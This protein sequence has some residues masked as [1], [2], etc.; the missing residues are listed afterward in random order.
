MTGARRLLAAALTAAVVF[1]AW[2]GLRAD[3]ARRAEETA[4]AARV[5]DLP[6]D[7]AIVELEIER[8]RDGVRVS[9]ARDGEGVWRLLEPIEARAAESAIEG[10]LT[11]L[12]QRESTQTISDATEAAVFGF[13]PPSAVVR[14]RGADGAA[15]TLE[16]GRDTPYGGRVYVRGGP[17]SPIHVVEG[18]FQHA[19]RRPLDDWRDRRLLAGFPEEITRVVFTTPDA[20]WAITAAA[21][22]WFGPAGEALAAAKVEPLLSRIRFMAVDGFRPDDEPLAVTPASIMVEAAGGRKATL[23]FG[24]PPEGQGAVAVD[25]PDLRGTVSRYIYDSLW[26]RPEDLAPEPATAPESAVTPA[27]VDQAE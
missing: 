7:P 26:K 19:L 14:L 4:R 13:D 15:W 25:G 9:F 1:A 23:R 22:R 18:G 5:L 2:Y 11:P 21:D 8:P 27:P 6:D 20:A 17:S 12:R 10:L 16:V 24:A 3:K